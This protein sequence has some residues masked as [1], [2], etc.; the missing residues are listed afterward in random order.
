LHTDP[1]KTANDAAIFGD[2]EL[3]GGDAG[4]FRLTLVYRVRRGAMVGSGKPVIGGNSKTLLV[5]GSSWQLLSKPR[6]NS[7]KGKPIPVCGRPVDVFFN[8]FISVSGNG[9][10]R[11]RC[12][13]DIRTGR[14]YA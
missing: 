9:E 5:I 14:L 12:G 2:G 6:A 1:G 10:Y 11:T 7:T 13:L 3:A 8:D 4:K